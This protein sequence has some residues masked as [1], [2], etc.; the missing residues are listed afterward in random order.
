MVLSKITYAIISFLV[1]FAT[2]SISYKT[3]QNEQAIERPNVILILADDMGIGDLSSFNGGISKTPSLDRL[4]EEGVYFNNAYAGSAVCSPSRAALMTGRYPHRTGSVTLNMQRYPGLTRIAKNETTIGNIFQDNGYQTGLIGKWHNGLGEEYHPLQRGFDEFEGFVGFNIS[5]SYFEYSLDVQGTYHGVKDKYLTEDLTQRA[6]NF[7]NRHKDSPFFLL[8]THYAPHR[9][10][11]APEEFVQNYVDQG[12]DKN[13]AT[14]YAMIEVM[15]RGIGELVTELKDLGIDNETLL[16]FT[17]DNGPDPIPGKRFNADMKGTKYTV[18][19]G[20]IHVPFFIRWP[21]TI[22]P[23]TRDQVIH[24]TDVLPTLVDLLSLE[25][26]NQLEWDGGS[27]K[28]NLFDENVEGDLPE[29]RFWQWNRGVPMYSHNA[30]M[31]DGDWKLVRPQITRNI[32]DGESTAQPVLYNL[33]E[34][35]SESVDVAS[36]NQT[37]YRKMRVYLRQWS[38]EVETDR[39]KIDD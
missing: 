24:F 11:S 6:K 7:V 26:P 34:D 32:P 21:N 13:T 10:L 38:R 29:Y 28:E 16:I 1:C 17:S 15:D 5:E 37:Q 20:G 33:A 19:E 14:I 23:G 9:P 31:R 36:E 39:L 2:D 3:E 27:F 30:A 12:L 4:I 35:S 8:L 22:D 18:N 25:V